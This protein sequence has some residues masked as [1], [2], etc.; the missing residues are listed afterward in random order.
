MYGALSRKLA[1]SAHTCIRAF[2]PSSVL[3]LIGGA[4]NVCLRLLQWQV[5]LLTGDGVSATGNH[6]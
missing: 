6:K 1:A 4:L 3:A 5:M 2:Q